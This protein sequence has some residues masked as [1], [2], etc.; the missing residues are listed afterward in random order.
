MT[1]EE[2]DEAIEIL[3]EV[4]TMDDSIFQFN[5]AYLKALDAALE[6]LKSDPDGAYNDGFKDGYAD[7]MRR[8]QAQD[9]ELKSG[10][11]APARV[12]RR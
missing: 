4:K 8:V 10:V 12:A 5:P 1:R 9:C 6:A 3:E 2:R 11:G 7:A